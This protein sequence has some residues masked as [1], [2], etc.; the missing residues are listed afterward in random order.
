MGA[1]SR[2]GNWSI[3]LR[4]LWTKAAEPA[5]NK[6]LLEKVVPCSRPWEDYYEG[7]RRADKRPTRTYTGALGAALRVFFRC[8]FG[9]AFPQAATSALAT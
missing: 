9:L 2:R 6:P 3:S 7:L 1:H 5:H 4:L 8:D